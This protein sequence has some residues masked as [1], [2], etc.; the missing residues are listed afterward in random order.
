MSLKACFG[1]ACTLS[2]GDVGLQELATNQLLPAPNRLS[3]FLISLR[4]SL[5][6]YACA[7][8]L[9]TL[10]PASA[11]VSVIG[12]SVARSCAS[13][14]LYERGPFFRTCVSLWFDSAR[15]LRPVLELALCLCGQALIGMAQRLCEE[16]P[17]DDD[18]AMRLEVM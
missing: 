14:A 3:L 12:A 10:R 16:N 5:T 15:R 2:T 17:L 18:M 8:V 13:L 11:V 6:I 1:S 9:D 4:L 7:C